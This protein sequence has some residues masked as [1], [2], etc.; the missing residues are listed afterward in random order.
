MERRKFFAASIATATLAAAGGAASRAQ[1]GALREYYQL[2]RYSLLS[3][4][5]TKLTESYFADALIPALTRMGMGPVGAFRLDVGPETP[6]FYLL[7]PGSS[8]QALVELDLR[9]GKDADFL[10]AAD[11][12][13][14]ATSAAPAF[15][16]V[17]SS[18]LAAFEGW[19]KVTPPVSAATKTKRIFQLRTYESPS[20]GEHVR[21]VEM[22][23]SGEFEIFL[24]AGFH[25]VFFG[26][27]LIGARLPNLTYMLT[28][29]DQAELD[30][31]WDVFRNDPAWKKLSTSSRF[32]YDQIV[33]NI[34][35]L[36]L[37]PLGC[38]QI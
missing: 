14:N 37:G 35:N 19:P 31:K 25:P 11:P 26:D 16:R 21:K 2:R 33:T 8:V 20:D 38:S 5:Q 1:S 13:W 17:E 9:L 6:V 28:F 15:Q 24:K 10:K 7:I 12:F 30:A 3:G 32:A 18:L 36:I 27:T 4:P 22:F 23:Q 29:A 34:T